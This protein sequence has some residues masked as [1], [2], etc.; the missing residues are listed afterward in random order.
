MTDKNVHVALTFDY[1]AMSVWIGGLGPES[2][3][4]MSRGEFC[5][6]GARRILAL[7]KEHDIKATFFVPG[8]TALAFPKTVEDIAAGGHE[9]GHHGWVHENPA[10]LNAD[11]E[12]WVMDKGL[13]ALDKVVGI[14]PTGY[15]S[16]GW[17][18]TKNTIS[19][20]KEYGFNYDSSLMGS[21]Y[22]PYWCRIGDEWSATGPWKFGTPVDLVELPVSWMLDDFL[23]FEYVALPNGYLPGG[24]SP[25]AVLQ[26]W[27]DE[28]D[29]LYERIGQGIFIPTMHPQVTGRGAR[30][31]MLEGLIKHIAGKPGVTFGTCNDYV[32]AWRIGKT[33]QLPADAVAG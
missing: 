13:E 7:L 11:Q 24:Q 15:R 12:R 2:P 33:P 10:V 27:I 3:S 9:I 5:A 8:H 22:E 32:D 21:E 18:T 6:Q 23:Y 31:L 16:P 1:D 14:R 28:F 17:E 26:T 20:L 29:Y 30:M 19:L 25:R 4:A